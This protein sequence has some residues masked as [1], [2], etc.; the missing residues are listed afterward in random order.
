MAVF[1]K[2]AFCKCSDV[3]GV[4]VG[5]AWVRVGPKSDA[6]CPS[7]RQKKDLGED[8]AHIDGG[9][10]RGDGAAGQASSGAIRDHGRQQGPP[11]QQGSVALLT[12]TSGSRPSEL[13]RV[14]VCSRKARV[15]GHVLGQPQ[16]THAGSR[17]MQIPGSLEHTPGGKP[18]SKTQGWGPGVR[19]RVRPES[20]AGVR[21]GSKAQG[22]GPGVR[23]RDETWE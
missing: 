13:G 1:G 20:H 22:W 9:R 14:R 5:S 12:L 23:C 11:D 4:K 6:V 18:R 7:G 15:C 19:C 21:P 2:R 10:G 3:E 16:G 17:T 8:G